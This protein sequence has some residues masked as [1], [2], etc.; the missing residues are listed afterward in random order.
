M[1]GMSKSRVDYPPRP[2][3]I[4]K[5]PTEESENIPLNREVKNSSNFEFYGSKVSH[6]NVRAKVE[7]MPKRS[8][9]YT[10]IFGQ[11][12]TTNTTSIPSTN[13]LLQKQGRDHL[14]RAPFMW[15]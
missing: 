8:I 3:K 14:V 4:T 9:G 2:R 15:S 13:L 12:S 5:L 7:I 1:M 11:S 10:N 6:S